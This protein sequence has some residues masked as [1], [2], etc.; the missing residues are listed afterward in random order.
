[1]GSAIGCVAKPADAIGD[2]TADRRVFWNVKGET[3]SLQ[4]QGGETT[5]ERQPS[6]FAP[7][8]S[9]ATT[10]LRLRQTTICANPV[11][12]STFSARNEG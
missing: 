1:M 7:R 11:Q 3:W 4:H 2:T 9:L 6:S 10:E 8:N 12:R 5:R